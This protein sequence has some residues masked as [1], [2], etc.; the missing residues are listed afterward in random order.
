MATAEMAV[1]LDLIQGSAEWHAAHLDGL[2]SSALPVIV[3]E[4]PYQSPM[5]LWAQMTGLVPKTIP[6]AGT[7][8]LMD[9]GKRMEPVL[10]DLYEAETGRKARRV[11]RML[12]HPQYPWARASLDAEAP[13]KRIVEAKWTH[14][15]RWYQ[16]D[17]VPVDVH[18]QVQWQMFVAGRDVADVVAL[19][20]PEL[21]VVEIGRD[22]AM[23]D[24]LFY[25]A[26]DFWGHVQD[27]TQ[28]DVDG[29]DSTRRALS[30]IHPADDGTYLTPSDDTDELARWLRDAK[31]KAKAADEAEATIEN[32]IRAY[33]GD[34]SGV[35]GDGYSISWKRNADSERTDWKSLA[36]AYREAIDR[37][38]AMVDA[39]DMSET[40]LPS[41][42][43]LDAIASIHTTTTEGPRVLRVTFAKEEATS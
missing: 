17:A 1:R 27:R 6:D 9:I 23:I 11:P 8:R 39:G 5:E 14:A 33:L 3:G 16:G 40:A 15:R 21:R 13:V 42:E 4:S 19:V 20:G 36:A 31:A 28:P 25:L 29:S 12:A 18:I 34:A 26:S 2:G 10:L 37:E 22:Q 41:R 35:K 7:Q 38:L 30:R 24:D 32:A 43:D